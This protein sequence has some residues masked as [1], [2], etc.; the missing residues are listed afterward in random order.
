MLFT[1]SISCSN[2]NGFCSTFCF[3]TPTGRTCGCQDNVNIQSDQLT[4]EGGKCCY[5]ILRYKK[6]FIHINTRIQ[7][8]YKNLNIIALVSRC[9][10]VLQNL[11]F[12][13]CQPYPGQSCN[14][15]CKTGYRLAINASVSCGSSGQW[16][17]QTD[18]LCE[19]MPFIISIFIKHIQ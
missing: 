14:F 6:S 13:D 17:L 8:H 10:T 12:L 19:G 11:N 4:C 18:T 16:N 7:R 3:P 5:G 2:K 9:P 15:E 1:V